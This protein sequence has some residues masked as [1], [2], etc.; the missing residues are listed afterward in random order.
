MAV[1]AP[2]LG[3]DG[4]LFL[5]SASDSG[6]R[7]LTP[8]PFLQQVTKAAYLCASKFYSFCGHDGAEEVGM[9]YR[10]VLWL[11]AMSMRMHWLCA[12]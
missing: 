9:C 8:V 6:I 11:R 3:P 7:R 4:S 2:T 12:H 10:L 1:C 5:A